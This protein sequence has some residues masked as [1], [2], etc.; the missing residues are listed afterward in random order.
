MWYWFLR[1]VM[2]KN[3]HAIS[4]Y[5]YRIDS[6]FLVYQITNL[7]CLFFSFHFFPGLAVLLAC[8]LLACR[9]LKLDNVMLDVMGHVRLADMGMCRIDLNPQNLASTFCGT[10]DYIAPEVRLLLIH[11]FHSIHNII[12][13]AFWNEW[14]SNLTRFFESKIM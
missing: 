10:P 9:D 4:T 1:S 5:H 6:N 12:L 2:G 3:W 13:T 8:A 7:L 11:L 14:R